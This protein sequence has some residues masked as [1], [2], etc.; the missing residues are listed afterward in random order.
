MFPGHPWEGE[1]FGPVEYEWYLARGYIFNVEFDLNLK[2]FLDF[3]RETD[4]RSNQLLLKIGTRLSAEYLPQLTVAL[5]KK[6]YPAR[7][8]AGYVRP[9]RPDRDMLEHIGLR[10]KGN[11]F[12]ERAIRDDWQPLARWFAIEHPK[13]AVWLGLHIFPA[14]EVKNNYALLISRNPLRNLGTRVVFHGTDYRT[15]VLTIPYGNQI[16]AT[17]GGP[18]AFGNIQHFEPFLIKFKSY[19]EDP[20]SIPEDIVRKEY[21]AVPSRPDPDAP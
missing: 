19:M 4:Q 8:P 16:T 11:H 21:R 6:A 1:D 20:R 2:P 7:Y 3:C 14:Q 9:L 17:F 5:N 12:A 15:M 10:E 18:H 13:L